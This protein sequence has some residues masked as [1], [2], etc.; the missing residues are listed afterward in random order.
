METT[1]RCQGGPD[2]NEPVQLTAAPL[3][4]HTAPGHRHDVT[5]GGQTLLSMLSTSLTA[6]LSQRPE[7]RHGPPAAD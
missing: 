2:Q 1:D 7:D 5:V 6:S 3:F 4:R